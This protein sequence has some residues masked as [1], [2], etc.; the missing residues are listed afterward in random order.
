[1]KKD[2]I[3]HFVGFVTPLGPE[4][5]G[6]SWERYAK[7]LAIKKR[8][9]VFQQNISAGKN[10]FTYLSQHE[11][12]DRETTFTFMNERK[13]DHFPEHNVRVVH[14]GGYLLM[15]SIKKHPVGEDDNRLIAFTGADETDIEHYRK[16]PYHLLNIHQAYFENCLYGYIL[17]F[18]VPAP[19][20]DQLLQELKLRPG[21]ETSIFK[22]SLLPQD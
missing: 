7:R 15:D 12:I 8:E 21:V 10:K 13:S 11:W 20:V 1:M 14:L 18:F 19:V 4:E 3:V 22:E 16:L 9:T 2:T 17:E 5:F 6:A